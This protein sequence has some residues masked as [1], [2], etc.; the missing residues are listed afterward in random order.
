MRASDR[1]PSCGRGRLVLLA[2]FAVVAWMFFPKA[3][4]EDLFHFQGAFESR[5]TADSTRKDYSDIEYS[6]LALTP[7]RVVKSYD[8]S[9][10]GSVNDLTFSLKGDLS[11]R[12]FLDIREYAHAQTY[13]PEDWKSFSLDSYKTRQID[14]LLNVTYGLAFGS[15]DAFQLDYFN[16]IA[17]TPFDKAWD[18]TSNKGRVRFNHRM[19]DYSGLQLGGEYEEREYLN[20]RES[21][22]QEGAMVLDLSTFLPERYRY[23]PIGNT[24]RGD[25]SVF[26]KIPTGLTTS[27]A[28]DYYT[29]WTRKPGDDESDAK[30]LA[31]VSR[32]DLFL[33]LTADIRSRKRTS[34]D[35]A[36][37]Q[38]GGMFKA[39]YDMSDR[40]KFQFED[41][42]YQRKFSKESDQYALYDHLS[43][44]V[45]L[46]ATNQPDRYFTHII[47]LANERHDHTL[48]KEQDYQINTMQW[49]TYFS[50][51]RSATSLFMKAALTR[52]GQQRL[53]FADNDAFQAVF[54]YDY[55]MTPRFLLHFKDE[56]NNTKYLDYEEINYSSHVQNTWRIAFERLL[57]N[58]QGL[59]IGY[60]DTRS[61]HTKYVANDIVEKSLFF[62]WLSHF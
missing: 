38:P 39:I 45:S 48:R 9:F 62:N 5:T 41:T 47:T 34:I 16:G 46:G 28:V 53:L 52:Y 18:Y 12:S 33:N 23:T 40:L 11:S 30:Y 3:L 31:E 14:H 20:D 8:K 21:N 60:Q 61:T 13:Q 24:A 4:A 17:Q 42:C 55:P 54:G 22:F 51:G 2:S 10:F 56:W 58:Q 27:R 1:W 15:R 59:E 37:Y 57:S 35:N 43:N 44:R 26:E 36:Y 7:K 6:D 19:N 50:R 49:E 25:H 29:S 32:G